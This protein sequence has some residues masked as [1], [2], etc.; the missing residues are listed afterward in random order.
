MAS[1]AHQPPPERG[2]R[3]HGHRPRSARMRTGARR[4][5]AQLRAQGL[6]DRNQVRTEL[7]A[8]HIAASSA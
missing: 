7:R 6:A 3:G 1:F 5:A 4:S 8:L 2:R